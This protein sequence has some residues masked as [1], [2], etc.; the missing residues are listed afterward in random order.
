MG[1]SAPASR[2]AASMA[3]QLSATSCGS[4]ISAA[5]KHPLPATRELGH[6][7]PHVANEP[8]SAPTAPLALIPPVPRC[9]P[10]MPSHY[11]F[12]AQIPAAGWSLGHGANISRTTGSRKPITLILS[13]RTTPSRGLSAAGVQH[14]LETSLTVRHIDLAASQH[15]T[16]QNLNISSHTRHLLHSAHRKP[17]MDRPVAGG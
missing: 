17:D 10:T 7:P 15:L 9:R 16:L 13:P 5:P 8:V 2:S 6:L 4:I 3:A 14:C 1:M 11:V 12:W